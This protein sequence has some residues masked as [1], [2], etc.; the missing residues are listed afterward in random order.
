MTS[1]QAETSTPH[2]ET[3]TETPAAI[4]APAVDAPETPPQ[5]LP[6][7]EGRSVPTGPL[8]AAMGIE[9]SEPERPAPEEFSARGKQQLDADLE[10]E[11]NAALEG[12]S[13]LSAA[14]PSTSSAP[15][16]E[17]QPGQKRKGKVQS[18]HGDNVIVD[19][20][21]RES[22]L[23][24]L[25]QFDEGKAPA[26]GD[27]VE[28]LIAKV[29][30]AE[31][32]VHLNPA[33]A[34]VALPVGNW[35]ELSEGQV[36]ECTVT[37]SN[38]GGLEINANNIRGFLPASQVELGFTAQP[39]QYVG[40]K[41]RVKVLEVNPAKK[42]LVV[43][44][45]AYLEIMA[46]EVRE[47]AWKKLAVGQ[48]HTGK[49]KT[50]KDY[51]AFVDIGGVDGLLHVGEISWTRIRHPKDVLTEGQEVEVQIVGLDR[52]KGKISLGMKQLASSPWDAI[53]SKYPAN[54]TVRGTIT[55]TTEF[56][57][58]VQLEPGIEGM[59]H[60]SELDHRRVPRVTD[61]V[62]VGQELDLQVL[63]VDKNKRRIAL[64]LKAL[65]AKPETSRRK[66]SDE[67]LAPSGGQTYERK[68]KEPLKGGGTSTGGLLFGDPR[69]RG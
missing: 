4:A 18:I 59:I 44:R 8:A 65:T 61:I 29:D 7:D 25:K 9:A 11:I 34:G 13:G 32:L 3:V 22:G 10:S 39:D 50:L 35:D 54:T 42:N 31:G 47:E 33:R 43:S 23:L 36:I 62:K 69:P 45:R 41:I 40:Q 38:K 64:S 28:V 15:T 30:V 68:R 55:R 67:D 17:L 6:S 37:K 48:R 49:V 12:V 46:A 63:S 26:V 56:G 52:D 16:D 57:A 58:F 20:G 24:Q 27:E 14:P 51:G 19:I 5:A 53:E 2:S 66:V 60:I 21:T 1:D